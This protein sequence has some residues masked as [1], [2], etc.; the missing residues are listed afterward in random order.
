VRGQNVGPVFKHQP[1]DRDIAVD[2]GVNG[3]CND[4]TAIVSDATLDA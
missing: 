3:E 1:V 4:Q 2:G